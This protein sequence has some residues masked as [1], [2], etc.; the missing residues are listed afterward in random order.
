MLPPERFEDPGL[1]QDYAAGFGDELTEATTLRSKHVLE[2]ARWAADLPA[3][4]PELAKELRSE[5]V[6]ASVRPLTREDLCL[7]AEAFLATQDVELPPKTFAE[8]V[9]RLPEHGVEEDCLRE[10]FAEL[11]TGLAESATRVRRAAAIAR[12]L[13]EIAATDTR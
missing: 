2:R 1:E 11:P 3:D 6:M 12:L 10:L 7:R 8:A 13:A 5:L 4:M 9:T